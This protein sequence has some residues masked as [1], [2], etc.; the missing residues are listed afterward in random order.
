MDDA[1][2]GPASLAA[3]REAVRHGREPPPAQVVAR[4]KS[5][6]WFV[7]GSVC[8]GAFMGQVDSSIA[9][10]L[11]PR[12]E[13]EFGARLSTVSWVAVAY[14]LAMAAF[15]PIF[16]RLADMVGRKLL[17]TGGFLLF[18]L[19]SALCGFAPN[20]PVLIAFRV[21][22]GIGAA[23]LS[24]NSVAIVVAA[25]GPERRG[26]ALGIQSAA[27][28]VGLSA[29]P[30][31][32][33]LVLDALGWQ[34]VFWINVPVGLVGAVIGWL[35]IP[36]TKDLPDDG[37][38]DWKGAFLIVP[39][40]TALMAVLNEGY[41]WGVTSPAIVGCVLLGVILLTLFVRAERRAEAPLVDLKLFRQGAFVTGNVAGL[42]S[43][44]AL[45]G[46]MFLMPFIF[47]RAY[48]DSALAAGLRLSIVPV[49]L[50]V[51]APIGGALYDRIGARL[52]TAAGMLTCVAGLV[53]LFAA[54]A[55]TSGSL[56]QAVLALAVFGAGQGLFISPNNSAIMA[57]APAHLTGEAG[58]LL[59]VM[60]SV[61]ISVGIASAS[62]LLSWRLASLTG[63]GL[64][65]LHAPAS[66]LSSAGRDVVLLLGSFAAIAGAVSLVRTR[67]RGTT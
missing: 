61:G 16:G 30:A 15:L 26:R 24:S 38:F 58:G 66:L 62:A 6:R 10:M 47:V 46:L 8:V 13:V 49:M 23:L 31:L 36:L 45:F 4:L 52:V 12:L 60:R 11:L 27:Q 2:P 21:I 7:V 55:G 18:V 67:S 56:P 20:L 19:G 34:W 33:G 50:G 51:T 9:Q 37:R 14:L 64:N 22:Q 5:Y 54:M 25:A 44:A 3:V 39:A 40:L 53:L 35:V 43:Y 1:A 42:M 17:Y 59:N 41:A 48:G 29:G 28:A 65:T 32:G 57:A 63:S